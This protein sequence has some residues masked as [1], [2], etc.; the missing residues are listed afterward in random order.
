MRITDLKQLTNVASNDILYI[1]DVSDT[2][3]FLSGSSKR[4][5]VSNFLSSSGIP[6]VSEGALL[7]NSN[8]YIY[9]QSELFISDG[10]LNQYQLSEQISGSTDV[11]V[12]VNGINQIPSINYSIS[13]STLNLSGVPSSGSKIEVRRLY[14]NKASVTI[15][16]GSANVEYFAGNGLSSSFALSSSTL[17]LHEYDVLLSIDG[18]IQKPT[19]DYT[20]VGSNLSF[21]TPPPNNTEIE[22]RYLNPI[23]TIVSGSI[24]INNY[25]ITSSV[26]TGSS[27]GSGFP[28]SGS[29]II[30]GSLLITG[31]ETISGSLTVTNGFILGNT[32]ISASGNSLYLN[33]NILRVVQTAYFSSSISSSSEKG[34][35]NIR[36]DLLQSRTLLGGYMYINNVSP[37]NDATINLYNSFTSIL[38]QNETI[39]PS[40]TLVLTL[41]DF[42]PLTMSGSGIFTVQITSSI[43]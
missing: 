25:N 37:T 18:L 16:T 43:A 6:V 31:S 36:N 8:G 30:T 39:A 41:S 15:S 42:V 29:A 26:V 12:F 34:V 2:T 22:V 32:T 10:I 11:F 23:S 27:S 21:T 20:I 19:S 33:N 24:T 14:D 38:F 4:V 28:F 17:V 3:D 13:S 40:K 35:L 7:V 1:V 9:G 5:T